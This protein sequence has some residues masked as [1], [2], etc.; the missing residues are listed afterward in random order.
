MFN[1]ISSNYNNNPIKKDIII[2][3][4]KELS[5]HVIN[6]LPK[7]SDV[8]SCL[9]V[10]K[11]WK[12]LA[13][14]QVNSPLPASISI[15]I[16]RNRILFQE[17]GEKFLQ[18]KATYHSLLVDPSSFISAAFR[19]DPKTIKY[20]NNSDILL[21]CEQLKGPMDAETKRIIRDVILKDPYAIKKNPL[22]RNNPYYMLAAV[23][24]DPKNLVFASSELRDDKDIVFI[25]SVLDESNFYYAS[26]RLKKDADFILKIV[27]HSKLM[28]YD[29]IDPTLK[30][31][32]SFILSYV[33][34]KP[35]ILRRA[36]AFQSDRDVAIE[37]VSRDGRCLQWAND[38][39]KKDPV[40]VHIAYR[41][42]KD[43]IE[44]ADKEV[45]KQ[46]LTM[47][48]QRSRPVARSL[49]HG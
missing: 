36:K 33:K 11:K 39:L 41:Q 15:H 38:E 45:Q 18:A 13:E 29:D 40:V 49:R 2:D 10:C 20:F 6:F 46:I 1:L 23:M 42:N 25:A 24:N 9:S 4:P 5:F 32:R 37:A 48:R 47:N 17:D 35:E 7:A 16:L 27:R 21:L 34:V 19:Y 28:I 31:D 3:L 30:N 43:S 22:Y 12:K 44:F 8:V 26:D 14:E